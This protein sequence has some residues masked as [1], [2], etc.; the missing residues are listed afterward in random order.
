MNPCAKIITSVLTLLIVLSASPSSACTIISVYS[1]GTVLLGG[2]EDLPPTNAFMVMDKRGKLGVIYFAT[3]WKQWPL[4]EQSGINEK[5]LCFDINWIPKEELIPQPEKLR[6]NEW[7]ITQLRQEVATVEEL[8][9]KLFQYNWGESISYQVHF[10]DK[11][12]D[13][14]IIYPGL[15]GELT[16]SRRAK[17]SNYLISTN[18]NHGRRLRASWIG[19]D[20]PY[21]LLFDSKFKAADDMLLGLDSEHDASV[22]FLGSVLEATHR[23]WWFNTPLSIKTIYSTIFDPRNLHIYLYL[24][25]QFDHPHMIDVQRELAEGVPYKKVPLAELVSSDQQHTELTSERP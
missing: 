15:N 14:V 5:G 23:N 22:E 3:P 7:V 4:V 18:F 17:G 21:K 16:F 19:L 20:F 11:S 13:A 2:N 12:G 1:K 25:R 10:A 24:N 6:Q 8:L 9:E